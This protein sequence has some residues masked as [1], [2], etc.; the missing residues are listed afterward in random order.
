[1][2]HLRRFWGT[3]VLADNVSVLGSL[4][5]IFHLDPVQSLK[6]VMLSV[7]YRLKTK[8]ICT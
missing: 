5:Y 6:E 1:M 2:G 7:V 3:S 8:I 4:P